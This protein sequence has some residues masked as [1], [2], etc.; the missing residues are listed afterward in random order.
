MNDPSYVIINGEK[1]NFDTL[2]E[3]EQICRILA[4]QFP[5]YDLYDQSGVSAE[6][7]SWLTFTSL[8][9][10]TKKKKIFTDAITRL[11]SEL[12]T[13]TY[14]VNKHF[15]IADACIFA[16]LYSKCKSTVV[17]LG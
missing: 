14:L 10:K 8:K 7:D 11:S 5:Q 13:V 6:V 4:R 15:T 16:G 12:A 3:S 1:L 9:I 17:I 2:T